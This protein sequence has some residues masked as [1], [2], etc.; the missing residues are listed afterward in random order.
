MNVDTLSDLEIFDDD[1]KGTKYTGLVYIIAKPD[2]VS[3][4]DPNSADSGYGICI[5]A[6]TNKV[7]RD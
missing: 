5:N 4:T 2:K 1:S 7:I 3:S 6:K